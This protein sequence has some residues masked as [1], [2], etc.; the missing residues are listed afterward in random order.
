MDSNLLEAMADQNQ[1][2]DDGMTFY[3]CYLCNKIISKWDLEAN[4]ECKCGHGK[5]SPTN[6]TIWEKVVQVFKHPAIW[7]WSDV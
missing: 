5:I 6:L 4:H 2:S 7:K 3:R 1:D